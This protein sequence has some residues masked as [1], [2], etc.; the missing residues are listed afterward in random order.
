MALRMARQWWGHH[1]VPKTYRDEWITE[2]LA[3][4]G[5]LLYIQAI[6]GRTNFT[7]R[8]RRLHELAVSPESPD[9]LVTGVRAG[10]SFPEIAWARAPIFFLMLA[11]ELGAGPFRSLL[12]ATQHQARGTGISSEQFFSLVETYGGP[13]TRAM[14]EYWVNHWEPVDLEYEVEPFEEADGAWTIRGRMRLV[15]GTEDARVR[16][17]ILVKQRR[18]TESWLRPLL[19]GTDWVPFEATVAQRPVGVEFDPYFATL[20]RERREAE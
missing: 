8:L 13:D 10:P 5:A 1:I 17:P 14:A 15:G 3:A 4:H 19:H 18:R 12:T 7:G 9:P 11:D 2:G 20:I 6:R 16:V